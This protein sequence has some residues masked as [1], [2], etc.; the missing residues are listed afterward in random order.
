V[1]VLVSDTYADGYAVGQRWANHFASL[2]HGSELGLVTAYVLSPTEMED[3]CG[4]YALGCYG[5]N[6]LAFMGETVDGVTPEEVASH[7]YGHHVAA[8]RLNPP[9]LAV[10]W[11][12]K[13][14]AAVA[15]VCLRAKQG[16]AFPGNEDGHYT[17][18]PG[19]AF[20]EV[21]RVLN[22]LKTG[23]KEFLWPLVDWSFR[24]DATALAA[25]E[26]DV[27]APWATPTTQ[28][29]RARFVQN[30]KSVW[31]AT[32]KTPLDGSFSVTFRFP[33]AAVY[34]LTLLGPDGRTVVGQGLWSARGEK[35]LTTTI[36]GERSVTLRVTRRG[37][38]GRFSLR[39][40]HD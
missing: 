4:P 20:A 2:L 37:P 11:G 19:E 22:E 35:R 6:E 18:N 28:S 24:P 38:V 15:D 40:T 5:G 26:Q 13:R 14:W 27:V 3:L 12:T 10:D 32:M 30:G 1:R 9:W 17:Q 21:F 34:E 25:V 23:A 16:T 33:K 31:K 8:N 39:V 36:C 29:V 7:E